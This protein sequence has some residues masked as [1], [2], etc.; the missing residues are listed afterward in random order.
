M[1]L[2]ILVSDQIKCI[3]IYINSILLTFALD[4]LRRNND[5]YVYVTTWNLCSYWTRK[6]GNDKYWM[7]V[8]T[9]ETF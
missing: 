3:Y 1:I 9:F 4:T 8:N 5:R 2:N 7:R 6:K